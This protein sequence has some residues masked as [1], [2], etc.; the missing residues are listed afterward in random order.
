LYCSENHDGIIKSFTAGTGTDVTKMTAALKACE[1]FCKT[2]AACNACS[3]D[4]HYDQK[5]PTFVQW[6]AIPECGTQTTWAGAIAGDVSLKSVA[7][8][9]TMTL[10][11][12]ADKWFAI[13]LNA[14]LMA[15]ARCSRFAVLRHTSHLFL[16]ENAIGVPPFVMASVVP[17]LTTVRML[18]GCPPL[19]WQV[20]FLL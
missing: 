14:Q 1:A 16:L 17:S 3:V 18:S 6:L 8:V 12:P 4:S 20:W 11:G 15:D 10:S 5:N 13:G 19:L 9:A 7:G 2:D